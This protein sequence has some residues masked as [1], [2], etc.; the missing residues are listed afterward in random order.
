MVSPRPNP[1]PVAICVKSDQKYG[2]IFY[3]LDQESWYAE[4]IKSALYED[5]VQEVVHTVIQRA[6]IKMFGLFTWKLDQDAGKYFPN[7]PLPQDQCIYEVIDAVKKE[8]SRHNLEYT[9]DTEKLEQTGAHVEGRKNVADRLPHIWGC[10]SP[11]FVA[12]LLLN[13]TSTFAVCKN[14]NSHGAIVGAALCQLG[15][16]LGSL[17]SGAIGPLID[18]NSSK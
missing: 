6:L 18:S 15:S 9:N 13:L 11:G 5:P 16:V 7:L 10:I 14:W 8:I 1:L 4:H 3:F 12:K 2:S 17:E